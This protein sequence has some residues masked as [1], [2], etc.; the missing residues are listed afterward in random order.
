M[1]YVW[2]NFNTNEMLATQPQN[3]SRKLWLG[4]WGAILPSQQAPKIALPF[5]WGW[6]GRHSSSH[7]GWSPSSPVWEAGGGSLR[8][9]VDR[10][11]L[12]PPLH[13]LKKQHMMLFHVCWVYCFCL[14]ACFYKK[15]WFFKW[16]KGSYCS[17]WN[18]IKTAFDRVFVFCPD[19]MEDPQRL[20]HPPEES[21]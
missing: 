12:L 6:E 13:P 7:H 18:I 2:T 19:F 4:M 11:L 5:A 14:F 16:N 15:Y 8:A 21:N 10:L 17:G 20:K 1:N 9:K 3:I